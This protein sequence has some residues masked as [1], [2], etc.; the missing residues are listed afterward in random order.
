MDTTNNYN[1]FFQ[2]DQCLKSFIL[3]L[4]ARFTKLGGV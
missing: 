3:V 4:I 2:S 1:H